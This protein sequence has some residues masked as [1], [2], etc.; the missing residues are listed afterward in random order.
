MPVIALNGWAVE[1]HAMTRFQIRG[2]TGGFRWRLLGDNNRTLVVSTAMFPDRDAC[3]QHMRR[4]VSTVHSHPPEARDFGSG[5]WGWILASPDGSE[6]A[7]S[8]VT[9]TR[10]SECVKSIDRFVAIVESRSEGNGAS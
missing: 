2:V 1:G 8:L 6:M 4:A 3:Y 10:K 5:R 9:F 7:R